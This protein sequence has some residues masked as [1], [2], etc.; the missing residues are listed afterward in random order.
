MRVYERPMAKSACVHCVKGFVPDRKD[1]N[2]CRNV[3]VCE[4]DEYDPVQGCG[5]G[6]CHYYRKEGKTAK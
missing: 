5:K 6:Y 3:W 2:K 4:L 1:E